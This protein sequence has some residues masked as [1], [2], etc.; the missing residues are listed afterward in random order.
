MKAFYLHKPDG[1]PT[2]ISACGVC[3]TV[4]A[5][6]A[7]QE[8]CC[9]CRICGQPFTEEERK[10]RRHSH[11]ECETEAYQRREQERLE[12]AELLSD[13]DGWV[14][15]DGAYHN[16]GFF[17][18]MDELTDYLDDQPGFSRPEFVF[19]CTSRPVALLKLEEILE[20]ETEEC[21]DSASDDLKGIEEL[22]AAIQTF[23]TL[24]ADVLSYNVDY[25]H[26][27]AVPPRSADAV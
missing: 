23:N 5:V 24:N 7:E 18:D 3:G 17:A 12:K 15:C 16:D 22:D 25:K 26:K 21:Y 4:G 6:F 11:Y 14:Y 8:K 27:I 1:T 19:C 9:A 10:Q 2:Q 13:W 20:S